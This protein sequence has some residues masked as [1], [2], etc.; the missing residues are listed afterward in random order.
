MIK[1][2]R[3][4]QLI[5]LL[6]VTN[7]AMADSFERAVN[8]LVSKHITVPVDNISIS[9]ISP[10][11][12]LM[13]DEPKITLLNNKKQWGTMTI[14]VKCGNKTQYLQIKVSVEGH[15]F[16]ADKP[17]SAGTIIT[18][19]LIRSKLGRLDLLANSVILNKQHI[20]N[21]IALRNIELDEPIRTSM[22]QQNWH[23]KAGQMVK[24]LINGEGYV[25]ATKG[26]SLNNGALDDYISVKLN[27]GNI[28]EGIVTQEGVTI[29]DK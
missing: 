28:V 27:S 11:P 2:I 17:I 10:K 3:L 18:D 22:L 12:Q 21:H 15:Y 16:V 4:I 5:S 9:Y 26:K 8:D 6:L 13:C 29:F 20:I 19:A 1:V 23:I 14:G 25:I 24:V 7:I